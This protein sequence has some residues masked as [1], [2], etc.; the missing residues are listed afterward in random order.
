MDE[1]SRRTGRSLDGLEALLMEMW[2][3]GLIRGIDSGEQKRFKLA[4]WI[5]GI[6]EYQYF[7][8]NEEFWKAF[9][10]YGFK[11]AKALHSTGPQLLQILPVE[12]SIGPD[13]QVMP[14]EKIS[15]IIENSK[16]FMLVDCICRKERQLAGKGCGHPLDVCLYVS[17]DEDEFNEHNP[18]PGRRITKQ[19]AHE[20]MRRADEIGLVHETSNM[21]KGQLFICNCCGCS[22]GTIG[23]IKNSIIPASQAVNVHYYA[24]IDLVLCNGC[25]ICAEKRCQVNAIE[26]VGEVYRSRREQCIGCG[27]CVSKC[28]V[29][30]IKLIRKPAEDQLIP[31]EDEVQWNEK[32]A[33]ARGMD[34]SKYK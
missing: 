9:R 14:Y 19:E 4:P 31:P 6:Y 33:A 18:W 25:G 20:V 5:V 3:K 30:A 1:I 22:C 10:K 21:Q 28:P 8:E 11:Y 32:K 27:L 13:S 24:E 15:T 2:R 23:L 26:K 29:R 16:S 7:N 34:Y 17:E 12:Q